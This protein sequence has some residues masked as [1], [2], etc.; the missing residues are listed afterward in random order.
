MT[1]IMM[2]A[3]VILSS[4]TRLNNLELLHLMAD[5]RQESNI[6]G[7]AL[8]MIRATISV[9][10]SRRMIFLRAVNHISA[11]ACFVVSRSD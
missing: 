11:N 1:K 10:F 3:R 8:R 5:V 6:L 4:S 9:L 2:K 7:H